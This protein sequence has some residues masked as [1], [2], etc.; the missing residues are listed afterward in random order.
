MGPRN[1]WQYS[2]KP[3][4]GVLGGPEG[5]IDGECEAECGVRPPIGVEFE[6]ARRGEIG[7]GW[8]RGVV[9]LLNVPWLGLLGISRCVWEKEEEEGEMARL[10]FKLLGRGTVGSPRVFRKEGLRWPRFVRNGFS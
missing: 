1:S 5:G 4:A 2:S 9:K 7:C 8:T 10:A 6:S 3:D